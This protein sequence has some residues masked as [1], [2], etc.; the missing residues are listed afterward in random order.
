MR[1][2]VGAYTPSFAPSR[3]WAGE[4]G[5]R[6]R[7]RPIES[8]AGYPADMATIEELERRVEQLEEHVRHTLPAKIDAVACGLSLV[9]EDT[10]AIRQTQ[11]RHGELLEEI[12][13]RLPAD[14]DGAG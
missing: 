2:P 6:A 8:R 1:L 4:S 10:R 5:C 9:H 11:Q 12:V 7:E 3:E 13:R 14:P